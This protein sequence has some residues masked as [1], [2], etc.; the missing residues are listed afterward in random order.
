MAGHALYGFARQ[1][2]VTIG[3]ESSGVQG[4]EAQGW[5]AGDVVRM[6]DAGLWFLDSRFCAPGEVGRPIG[7]DQAALR[8]D[9]P[10]MV[11]RQCSPTKY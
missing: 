4:S 11:L 1:Q 7:P 5:S 8:I 9:L 6:L 3:L 10:G 2:E